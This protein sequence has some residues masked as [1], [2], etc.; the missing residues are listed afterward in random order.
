MAIWTQYARINLKK[1]YQKPYSG[2][3]TNQINYYVVP[4]QLDEKCNN[5]V[6]HNGSNDITK[7]N[8]NSV[9]AEELDHRII[10]IG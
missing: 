10:N 3:N 6:I 7:F 4:V 5:V 9:N 1:V 8:Y 2:A